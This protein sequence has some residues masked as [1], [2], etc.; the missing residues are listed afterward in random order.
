MVHMDTAEWLQRI[1]SSSA[2][3]DTIN[4][5]A[6]KSGLSH[7]TLGRRIRANSLTAEQAIAIARA[8][9]YDVVQALLD[10]EFITERDLKVPRVRAAL[11]DASDVELAREITRRL[12]GPKEHPVFDASL[13]DL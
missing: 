4:A 9:Q 12:A 10:L 2:G 1:T 7:V 5:I 13:T 11:A 6:I 3:E 8:Y